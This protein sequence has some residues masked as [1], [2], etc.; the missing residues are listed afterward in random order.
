[1]QDMHWQLD[2]LSGSFWSHQ[3]GEA[4]ISWQHAGVHQEGSPH[5]LLQM[6]T[7]PGH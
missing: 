6:L 7:S 4:S 3:T 1:M 2:G 5:G